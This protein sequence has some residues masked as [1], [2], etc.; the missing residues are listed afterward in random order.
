MTG[1]MTKISAN[2]LS[3]VPNGN[4]EKVEMCLYIAVVSFFFFALFLISGFVHLVREIA[5]MKY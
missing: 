1:M 4:A 5:P 3:Y 2:F